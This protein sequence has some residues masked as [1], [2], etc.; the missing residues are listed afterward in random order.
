MKA[1]TYWLKC[2]SDFK[3]IW[4]SSKVD[5]ASVN[6]EM[7]LH[8]QRAPELFLNEEFFIYSY[9]T[10]NIHVT[11]MLHNNNI[12]ILIWK[13]FKDSITRSHKEVH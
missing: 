1:L 12:Y 8:I 5:V 4:V 9:N 10:F 13:A 7:L 2:K 11:C 3:E 6:K